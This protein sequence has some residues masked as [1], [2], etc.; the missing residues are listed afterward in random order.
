MIFLFFTSPLAP[1]EAEI[2]PIEVW[3]GTTTAIPYQTSI[4]HILASRGARGEVKKGKS[5]E[6]NQKNYEEVKSSPAVKV[7]LRDSVKVGVKFDKWVNFR[8]PQKVFFFDRRGQ[9]RFSNHLQIIIGQHKSIE[10]VN[11]H[12]FCNS[13]LLLEKKLDI[14]PPKIPS[15]GNWPIWPS[16]HRLQTWACGVSLKR[17]IKN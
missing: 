7:W 12:W 8:V 14:K 6:F 16:G 3:Y 17:T 11:I 1:L 9:N 4:G 13:S 15:S 10:V 2:C 5:S